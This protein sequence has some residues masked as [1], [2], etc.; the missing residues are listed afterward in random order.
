MK[1]WLSHMSFT[2][3]KADFN[4]L[5]SLIIQEVHPGAC[6]YIMVIFSQF[7]YQR[8][9]YGKNAHKTALLRYIAHACALRDGYVS[10][11]ASTFASPIHTPSKNIQHGGFAAPWERERKRRWCSN[12]EGN[13]SE[14]RKKKRK[15]KMTKGKYEQQYKRGGGSKKH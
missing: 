5:A 1:E 10:S 9:L 2:E 15:K 4:A 11:Y 8:F 6:N 12:G 3:S 14:V 7:T 13:E